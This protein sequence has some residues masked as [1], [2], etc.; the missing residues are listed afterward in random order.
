MGMQHGLRCVYLN[1]LRYANSHLL[2][3]APWR[4]SVDVSLR[5]KAG[6]KKG[7]ASSLSLSHGPLRFVTSHSHIARAYV[8][9]QSAQ[10]QEAPR[11]KQEADHLV[12]TPAVEILFKHY[13]Y[14]RIS[15]PNNSNLS[16]PFF[17]FKRAGIL[18]MLDK[19][20]LFARCVKLD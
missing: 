13:R 9:D 6:R 19:E 8:R 12:I 16:I 4:L 7:F 15:P 3:L 2:C 1:P 20:S 10:K 5:A 18:T 14:Y 17:V 11:K